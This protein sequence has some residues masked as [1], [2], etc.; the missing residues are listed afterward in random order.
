MAGL[1]TGARIPDWAPI[2]T[3]PFR[4]GL[5][6]QISAIVQVAAYGYNPCLLYSARVGRVCEGHQLDDDVGASAGV[7]VGVGIMGFADAS[8]IISGRRQRIGVIVDVTAVG[9]AESLV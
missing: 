7:R 6:Y 9:G 2:V 8:V 4:S 5:V 1:V 3:H